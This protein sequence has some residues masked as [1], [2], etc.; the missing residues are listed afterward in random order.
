MG[1][2][3]VLGSSLNVGKKGKKHLRIKKK[4]KIAHCDL[5]CVSILWSSVE[6]FICYFVV[7]GLLG[8]GLENKSVGTTKSKRMSKSTIRS[9][10]GEC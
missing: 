6:Q 7:V 8:V 4:K 9:S 10:N 5:G 2:W 1:L 3:E